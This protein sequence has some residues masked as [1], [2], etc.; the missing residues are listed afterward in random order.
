MCI[1][2]VRLRTDVRV[3]KA[4]RDAWRKQFMATAPTM[5]ESAIACAEVLEANLKAVTG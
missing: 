4:E 2:N 3:A 1:E 5:E